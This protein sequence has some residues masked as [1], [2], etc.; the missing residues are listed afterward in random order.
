MW[1]H[2]SALRHAIVSLFLFLVILQVARCTQ[3]PPPDLEPSLQKQQLL[4]DVQQ[5]Q[6]ETIRLFD[7]NP[8]GITKERA[9]LIVRFCVNTADA[10]KNAQNG[11]QQTVKAMWA[12]LVQQ[13]KVPEKEIFLQFWRTDKTV[14]SLK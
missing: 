10:V 2:T 8:R 12:Q 7:A 5:L 13:I 6:F 4:L 14:Q 11:W 1:S 9:D 3:N